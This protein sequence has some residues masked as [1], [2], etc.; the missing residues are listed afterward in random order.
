M[1]RRFSPGFP[2]PLAVLAVAAGCAGTPRSQP[3]QERQLQQAVSSPDRLRPAEPLSDTA[4][5]MLK[6]RMAS[7]ARDMGELVSEIMLLHYD[8]IH[9]GAERI[10]GDVSLSRPLAQDASELNSALPE[11]FFLYQDAVRLEA[12]TL[13]E[14]AARQNPFDV[15]DAYGRLSQVCVR[16]HAA[17][18]TGR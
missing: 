16:C 4:R 5:A 2:F 8:R 3:P 7:H 10:A 11:K 17:Y 14:A 12:R 1:P 18:R 6:S 13:A 15:A 9:D